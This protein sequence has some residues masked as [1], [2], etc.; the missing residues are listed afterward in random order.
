MQ[1]VLALIAS[2]G[3]L[4]VL[5]LNVLGRFFIQ[6]H[7]T[8]FLGK[9]Q[10][11]NVNGRQN[12]DAGPKLFDDWFIGFYFFKIRFRFS[13]SVCVAVTVGFHVDS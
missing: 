13:T 9:L 8:I 3:V 6:H 12:F 2:K 5:A 1:D 10:V 4:G 11:F 7:R